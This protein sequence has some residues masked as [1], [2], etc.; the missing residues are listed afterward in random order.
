[1]ITRPLTPRPA[2]SEPPRPLGV[3]V[4]EALRAPRRVW[5]FNGVL[6]LT[7]ALVWV[8][9]IDNFGSPTFVPGPHL[10][11]WALALAFYF[12]EVFVVHLQFRK[13]AHTLSLTEIGLTLGLLL[14]APAALLIGQLAGTLVALI[15]TRWKSQRQLVKFAFNL[16]ELPLCSG[17]ALV[18]FRSLAQP[19][20]SAPHV[21][22]LV[23]FACAVA[24]V[25]GILLV[26]AVIAIAE[27]RF[28]APQLLRTLLTS[29]IG[30]LATA[31]LGLAVVE[32]LE[33]RPL[34]V[35]LLVVPVLSC[36][37]AFRGYMEQ[38]ETPEHVE[39][40]YE[41][42]RA[43][44]GAPEFG[45]AVGQLL[46]AARRLLRAEYAEILLL[47]STPGEPVLR[48]VSGASGETLM[49]PG[50]LAP[51][52]ELAFERVRACDHSLL[53]GRRRDTDPIDRFLAGRGLGDAI[54]GPLRGEERV[55]GIL[56]VGG[57]VGDVST[58]DESDLTLFETFSGH[59]SVL[60]ENGRL[61]QSL[62][63][64]TELKEELKHQAYHDALTGLPNRVLFTE[65]VAAA[66]AEKPIQETSHAV[67]FLDLDRF[68]NVN[69]SW[70]HEA[71]DELLVQVAQRLQR[72]IRPEDIAARL[73]GDEFAVL[74]EN[75]DAEGAEHAA[76]RLIHALEAPFS[77]SGKE[78][79]VGA[80]VGIALTGESATTAADLLR[81]ADIAMYVAKGDER[82]RFAAYE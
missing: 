49:R 30:A 4:R 24:H 56:V 36:V 47:T 39:F 5:I 3:A 44:Q 57:R 52:D 7:C 21:W 27:E 63:Q 72:A 18:I 46:V 23:L 11:W 80:S 31:S 12:A 61:E 14:G 48:S 41:S 17:V 68:K 42:M 38:R 62:A 73:G 35:V 71:G 32:L 78:A 66:L 43:T 50:T 1:M 9:A 20:D 15:V 28:Q 79:S 25:L 76:R 75:T 69:D 81:N 8:F 77:L 67:L 40:L 34:A 59:A 45:L 16:A 64:L 74:L 33:A 29:T 13:Q 37:A 54:I 55:F 19:G 58:F 60:L 10:S 26:S 6:A 82:K 22:V 70:G 65:R 53:L 51:S 2:P